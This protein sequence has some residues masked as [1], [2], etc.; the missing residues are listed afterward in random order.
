MC[1]IEQK[2]VFCQGVR[3]TLKNS[4][5][6]LDKIE[7]KI[8]LE[9]TQEEESK[10]CAWDVPFVKNKTLDQLLMESGFEKNFKDMIQDEEESIIEYQL[11]NELI[12]DGKMNLLQA[13]VLIIRERAKINRNTQKGE[14]NF[15][16]QLDHSE[17]LNK[18]MNQRGYSTPNSGLTLF[19][20]VNLKVKLNDKKKQTERGSEEEKL[21]GKKR[22]SFPHQ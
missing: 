12:S 11:L 15:Q 5:K 8:K 19:N 3:E 2:V 17:S 22:D 14:A 7:H 9:Q 1:E 21:E 13:M 18:N 16:T 6:S 20:R 4:I 10:N